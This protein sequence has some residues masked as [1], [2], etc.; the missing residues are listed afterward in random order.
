M[1]ASSIH[2]STTFFTSFYCL[3]VSMCH[4]HPQQLYYNSHNP[5]RCPLA[6]PLSLLSLKGI[7]IFYAFSKTVSWRS[8]L[9]AEDHRAWTLTILTMG[10][11]IIQVLVQ[12]WPG[13]AKVSQDSTVVSSNLLPDSRTDTTDERRWTV[14][15][16]KFLCPAVGCKHTELTVRSVR[17]QFVS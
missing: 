10:L 16:I 4:S 7:W 11:I 5:L 9:W 3:C 14:G 6:P 17:D 12:R 2:S 15:V 8:I 1:N 13:S